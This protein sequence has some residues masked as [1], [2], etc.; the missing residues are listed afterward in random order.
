MKTETVQGGWDSSQSTER[1][2]QGKEAG[3]RRTR[4][5][6]NRQGGQGQEREAWARHVRE[7]KEKEHK[8]KLQG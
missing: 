2:G 8:G 1:Q 3:D 6:R 4:L 5:E 7:E